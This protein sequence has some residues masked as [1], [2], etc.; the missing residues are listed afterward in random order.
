MN[1]SDNSKDIIPQGAIT[2]TEH[3]HTLNW[4]QQQISHGH[5][6]SLEK[7][8]YYFITVNDKILR[9]SYDDYKKICSYGYEQLVKE[10]QFDKELQELLNNEEK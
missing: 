1:T 8:L 10:Q 9:V 2:V 6:V 5:D 3:S 4:D 7:C